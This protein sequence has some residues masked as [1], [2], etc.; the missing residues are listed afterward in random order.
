MTSLVFDGTWTGLL[1]AVY[2]IYSRKLKQTKVVRREH[3]QTEVFNDVILIVSD[4]LIA[5]RIWKGLSKFVSQKAMSHLYTCFLSE[6]PGI[7]NTICQFIRQ[8]FDT[9][10]SPEHAYANSD[11]LR[12]SQVERMVH[13]EKHRMEAFIRFQLTGDNLYFANIEPDF[14]VL[15]LI[16]KH[17]KRRYADQRWLVYD[18]KRRYG[19]YYDLESVSE[20]TLNFS[21]DYRNAGEESFVQSEQLYQDLWREYF[22]HVN[23][24]ERKNTKLHLMHVPRRYWKHLTEKVMP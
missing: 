3:F 19:I 14:N 20:V 8:A 9:K 23:I 7:E 2:E 15:P 1:S 18:L 11:V 13:R 12:I 17:F 5:T 4:V 24:I 10:A 16:A 21:G 22:K 6:L